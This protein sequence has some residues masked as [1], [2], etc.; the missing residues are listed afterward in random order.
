[1]RI[2]LDEAHTGFL[3]ENYRPR[4]GAL[5]HLNEV[6]VPKIFLTATLVPTHEKVLAKSV[7]VSL[8]RMLILRSRTA[9]RNHRLQ[10]VKVPPEQSRTPFS[11]GL[12]LA[13]LLLKIWDGDQAVRGI[14]FVRSVSKLEEL[15]DSPPFPVCTYHGQMLDQQKADQLDSWLSDRHPAKW[16]ISTTALLHGVDYP[17]VDA[18]IFLGRPFGVYDFVQGAGRA[19]RSGQDSLVVVLENGKPQWPDNNEYTCRK[20]M[21]KIISVPECRRLGL[22]RVMD[23]HGLPCSQVPN[24]LLCDFCEGRLIP[25]ITDA[26]NAPPPAANPE[27]D[28]ARGLVPRAPPKPSPVTMVTG[29]AAQA[30][31]TARKQHA[32][33][34]KELMEKY[35]GCFAC[36][37]ANNDHAPCH[38]ECGLSD[39]SG[40]SE[41]HHIPFTCTQFTYKIGWMDWKKNIKWPADAPRC[42]FCGLP[43]SAAPR[44][45]KVKGHPHPGICQFSDSAIAA[46]WHIL[47]TPQLFEKLQKELGYVPEGDVKVGFAVWLGQYGSDSEDVRLLSVF[48]WLCRQ[49]YPDGV[50]SR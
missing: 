31:T 8:E 33:Y 44:S 23:G 30:N 50:Y 3:S 25:L 15:S 32:K 22:S 35:A 6:T 24:S 38:L 42:Y 21:D 1:V 46:A 48:G 9:R 47:H 2:V 34:I 5:V 43:E 49:Y 27:A 41:G 10:F 26:F 7:G 28:G 45:H 13:S 16:I 12:Q 40:C 29:Y 18:V 19:G 20:E 36:R 4:M 14:I 11:V 39:A 37:I 17:R